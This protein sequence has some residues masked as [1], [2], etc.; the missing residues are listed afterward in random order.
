MWIDEKQRGREQSGAQNDFSDD[1]Q[2]GLVHFA[3]TFFAPFIAFFS[4]PLAYV[5]RMNIALKVALLIYPRSISTLPLELLLRQLPNLA[6]DFAQ[7]VC[8]IAAGK[9]KQLGA[10]IVCHI[11]CESHRQQRRKLNPETLFYCLNLFRVAL[12]MIFNP[13][14]DMLKARQ[15]VVNRFILALNSPGHHFRHLLSEF[16]WYFHFSAPS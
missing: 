12:A 6:E 2:N 8:A 13:F 7:V 14:C 15:Q 11:P 4:R 3:A 16:C 10:L 1:R 5:S 9:A